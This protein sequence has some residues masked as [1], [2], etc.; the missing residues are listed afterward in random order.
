MNWVHAAGSLLNQTLRIMGKNIQQWFLNLCSTFQGTE[1]THSQNNSLQRMASSDPSPFTLSRN[2]WSEI[3]CTLSEN[4]LFLPYPTLLW[5]GKNLQK[6]QWTVRGYSEFLPTLWKILSYKMKGVVN[7]REEV[8]LSINSCDLMDHGPPGSSVHGT[9]QARI[10]EWVVIPSSRGPSWPKDWTLSPA[11]PATAGG[12]FT[13]WGLPA[14]KFQQQ[15]FPA[16][17]GKF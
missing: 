12:F 17:W 16:P 14:F 13:H 5:V 15:H 9:L 11:S 1:S 6:M 2:L 3:H 4:L 10:L 7:R 8:S